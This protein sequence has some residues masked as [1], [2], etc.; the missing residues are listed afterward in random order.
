MLNL[1]GN[2]ESIIAIDRA[3][4]PLIKRVKASSTSSIPVLDSFEKQNSKIFGSSFLA[5]FFEAHGI[6]VEDIK[7][8]F[9]KIKD[10]FGDFLNLFQTLSGQSKSNVNLSSSTTPQLLNKNVL[11]N[12][13]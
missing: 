1:I 2:Y 9:K 12:S 8:I 10:N 5:N 7:K 4:K 6:K 13:F 11:F 3:Y